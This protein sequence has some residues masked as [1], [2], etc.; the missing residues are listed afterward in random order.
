[1]IDE[2]ITWGD[3]VQTVEK[4]VAKNLG[5][6]YRA[7]HLLD[8]DSLKFICFSYIHFYLDYANTAWGS[9][10]FTILKPIY[11]QQKYASQI[12]FNKNILSHS[13]PILRLLHALLF[14]K[15]GPYRI[16]SSPL[17]KTDQTNIQLNF[18]KTIFSVT[19]FSLRSGKYSICV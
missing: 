12:M 8:N 1:M 13:R 5:L 10:Y 15:G 9:T 16:E 2:N 11:Y 19:T 7:K 18:P 17:F 6:L 14:H 4:K 3:R